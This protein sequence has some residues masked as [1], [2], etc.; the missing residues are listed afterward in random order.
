[1]GQ[2]DGCRR[3]GPAFDKPQ[4]ARLELH[5][6]RPSPILSYANNIGAGGAGV[7]RWFQGTPDSG[8]QKDQGLP[9][10]VDDP[11]LCST[12]VIA[13]G[14]RRELLGHDVCFEA[15]RLKST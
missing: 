6:R 4:I 7:E 14:I 9:C 2:E 3:T 1:M 13:F 5:P 11:Y 12:Q 8:P 10:C 15:P